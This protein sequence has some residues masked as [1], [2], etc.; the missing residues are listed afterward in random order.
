MPFAYM[1]TI[2]KSGALK[3]SL[4]SIVTVILLEGFAGIRV[5]SLALLSDAAHA[6][7]DAFSTLILLISARIALKPA[8]KDHTYGHG[9]V[10]AIGS[11]LGGIILFV[12][13]FI[14][15]GEAAQRFTTGIHLIHPGLLGYAAA[16]YTLGID[17]IRMSVLRSA[18][19]QDSLSIRA[20]WYDAISDFASTILAFVGLTSSSL[21]YPMGDTI[22]SI[23]VA[24]LLGYL[25]IKL[26]H[27]TSMVLTD[28]VSEE[29]VQSILTEIKETDDVLKCK[30]L[31]VRHVGDETFVD[32]VI[33][34][35]PH[36]GILDADTI[37]SRIESRLGKLLGKSTV[38]VHIEPIEWEIP[39]EM[40]VRSATSLVEGARD[41]H[42]LSVT[43]IEDGHYVILH[44]RVDPSLPLESAHGI[45]EAVERSVQIAIPEVRRVTVHIEPSVPERSRGLMVTDQSISDAIRSIV[46]SFPG[47]AEAPSVTLYSTGGDFHA[48]ISCVFEGEENISKIHDIVSSIEDK[49]KQ[50]YGNAIITIHAEPAKKAERITERSD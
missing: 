12:L 44:L 27:S 4:I 43:T 28:A 39:I 3:I 46:I 5:G 13:A 50:R 33:G 23:A 29:L 36:I 10:E 15:I 8:D 18:L 6:A 20:G 21:G 1:V 24:S 31:R 34:T 42:N 35:S 49:I 14:I 9:K 38:M 11:M 40:R 22:A 25:G 47:V 30:E 48:D 17:V 16:M 19:T 32:T 26:V 41:V 37:A 2:T 45:A 7:F